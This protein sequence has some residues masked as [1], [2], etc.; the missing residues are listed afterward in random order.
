MGARQRIG[1]VMASAGA[2]R[3][4]AASGINNAVSRTAGIVALAI[5]GVI[6]VWRFGQS[7]DSGLANAGVPAPVHAAVL[8]E[9]GKLAGAEVPN[10]VSPALQSRVRDVIDS[11]FVDAFRLVML[12]SSGLAVG[13]AASAGILIAKKAGGRARAS[14]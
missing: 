9:K 8:A 10:T 3:S 4:G 7:L 14:K 1:A 5:F 6:A 12:I 2:E 11:S 13:A